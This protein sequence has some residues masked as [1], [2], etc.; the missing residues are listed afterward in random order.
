MDITQAKLEVIKAGKLLCAQGLIQRT[1]GNVSCR[2]DN[3][4]FAITPS[5]R[6]YLSLTPDDIVVVNMHDLAYEGDIKP[7]SEK[8]IHAQCYLDKG[9]VNFVIH[10]HQTYASLFGITGCD[11]NHLEGEN[12]AII[13]KHVPLAAY[14]LPGTG[15]L[16]NG[17]TD[18]IHRTSSKAVLMHHHGALCMG[19]DLDDA[20][21][22]AN[23]L[24]DA[25]KAELF[26]R[27]TVAAGK[28]AEGFS[29]I[30]SF[31]SNCLMTDTVKDELEAYNSVR[32]FDVIIM[33][34]VDGGESIT[35]DIRTGLPLAGEKKCPD[36]AA[37]HSMIY[38]KRKD[39]NAVIHSKETSTLEASKTGRTI[40]PYLDDF[41]QIVGINLKNALYDP[42]NALSSAR[43]ATAKLGHRDALLLKHN[44]A[45]CVGA[46]E[47]EADAVKLVTEKGCASYLTA[48]LYGKQDQ[49]INFAECALMRVIYKMKYSKKAENNK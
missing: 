14:G 11:I 27:Y 31:V 1:W 3:N 18:A 8:G 9:N 2:I 49:Y 45:L 29:S 46:N 16:R 21:K 22:V 6:D 35:V 10:T 42:S 7:S 41:A 37:L 12:A 36:T 20:F 15:K 25:C 28:A 17:V 47:D 44:G 5:G 34:P 38:K 24:E 33:T 19:E 32:E 48:E 39:V 4:F 26:K 43:K 13:G 23:A 30:A 40:R